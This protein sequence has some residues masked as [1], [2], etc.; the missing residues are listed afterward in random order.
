MLLGRVVSV[1]RSREVSELCPGIAERCDD[2]DDDGDGVGTISE[3]GEV[4]DVR[5]F[6]EAAAASA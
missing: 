5:R 2:R 4:V 3:E 1:S 6:E